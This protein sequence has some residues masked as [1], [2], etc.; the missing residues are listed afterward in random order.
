MQRTIQGRLGYAILTF[1]TAGE[2]TQFRNTYRKRGLLDFFLCKKTKPLQVNTR[3]SGTKSKTKISIQPIQVTD[4][5]SNIPAKTSTYRE[6]ISQSFLKKAGLGKKFFIF[7]IRK[8]PEPEDIIW[9]NVAYSEA[10]RYILKYLVLLFMFLAFLITS[11]VY[12]L[13]KH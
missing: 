6:K 10:D 7:S 13:L 3:P 1:G 5:R 8:A 4:D 11:L 9:E 12:L 2:A